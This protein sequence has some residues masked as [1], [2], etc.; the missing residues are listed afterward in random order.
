MVLD[1]DLEL[2]C[3]LLTEHSMQLIQTNVSGVQPTL[4]HPRWDHTGESSRRQCSLPRE[5]GLLRG[6]PQTGDEMCAGR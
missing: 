3:Q 6:W 1:Q 2:K 5:Q 4:G